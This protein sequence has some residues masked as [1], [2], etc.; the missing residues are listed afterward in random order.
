MKIKMKYLRQTKG[1]Y[2]YESVDLPAVIPIVYLR[3]EELDWVSAP[4]FLDLEFV[5]V[6]TGP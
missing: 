2:V 3:K 1:T 6:E 5:A 4:T